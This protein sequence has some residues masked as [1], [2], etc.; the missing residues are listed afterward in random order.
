VAL[1]CH[2]AVLDMS[3]LLHERDV[4][5]QKACVTSS[6][7]ADLRIFNAAGHPELRGFS[8]ASESNLWRDRPRHRSCSLNC[9][10]MRRMTPRTG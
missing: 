2:N 7:A 6:V 10:A 9:R 8:T 4:S 1:G 3:E 5:R